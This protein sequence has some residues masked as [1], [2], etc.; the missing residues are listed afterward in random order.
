MVEL[1]LILVSLVAAAGFVAVSQRRQRQLGMLAAIGS[2]PS[3]LRLVTLTNGVLVGAVSAV[4]GGT[5]G[6][7]AWVVGAPML[8]QSVGIRVDPVA[9]PWWLVG[10]ILALTIATTT[11]ASWWP[12]R[13]VARVPITEA[14]S[15]RRPRP[16]LTGRSLAPAVVVLAG[17][18]VA[19]AMAGNVFSPTADGPAP[20]NSLLVASGTVGI[21]AGVLMLS[22]LAVAALASVPPRSP[23]AVRL[24]FRDLAR[25]QSRSAAALAAVSLALG[26]PLALIIG[27]SAVQSRADEG[28]LSNQQ[29]LITADDLTAPFVTDRAPGRQRALDDEVGRLADEWQARSVVELRKVVDPAREVNEFGRPTIRVFRPDE[30]ADGAPVFFADPELLDLLAIAPADPGIELI[31]SETEG[32]AYRGGTDPV[33]GDRVAT[34]VAE[35]RRIAPVFSSLPTAMMTAEGLERRGWEARPAGWL[36][37]TGEPL[38]DGQ[39]AEA[40]DRAIAA[41]LTIESRDNQRGLLRL[42][43][44]ATVFAVIVALAIL[45]MTVGIV[46]SESG[47]DLRTLTATGATSHVR[48]GLTASTAGGLALLGVVLGAVGA[49]LGLVAG[50]VDDLS[51]LTPLPLAHLVAVVVGVPMVAAVAGWLVSGREPT[52]ISRTGEV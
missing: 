46:R 37:H 39:I 44:A 11:A 34:D 27:I 49:Y 26:M 7:V 42:R 36:I 33:T 13:M 50:F 6:L 38:T 32:F 47:R 8:E 2:P 48:R 16:P 29:L 35:M 19:V 9:I 25:Y 15:G 10:T 4:L 5:F 20:F 12:A 30:E 14:L 22:P 17:G 40:R 3:H 31:T 1:S 45:A 21:I 28:N 24:A 52:A 43:T 23:L 41:G 18:T 51:V